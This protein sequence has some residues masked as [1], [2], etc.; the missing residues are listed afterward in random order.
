MRG[1]LNWRRPERHVYPLAGPRE[2]ACVRRAG[3]CAGAKAAILS[4]DENAGHKS[5]TMALNAIDQTRAFNP[6]GQLP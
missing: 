2:S 3:L 6:Y 4:A 1:V 5:Q